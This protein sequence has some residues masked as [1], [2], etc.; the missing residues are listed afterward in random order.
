MPQFLQPGQS[1]QRR[2]TGARS[3]TTPARSSGRR[4]AGSPTRSP[5]PTATRTSTTARCTAL[6]LPRRLIIDPQKVARAGVG[7]VRLVVRAAATTSAARRRAATTSTS[8]CPSSRACPTGTPVTVT[9]KSSWDMEWDFDY[10]FVMATTDGTNYTSLPSANGY[11]TP[12]A[13]NPNGNGCQNTYGNGLTG[14]SG[15]AAGGLAQQQAD[16]ANA[17]VRSGL[18]VRRRRV[19]PL[20]AT[21][22]S[23]TSCC[24]SRT[25]PTRA[26]TAPGWFIDDL[27][28]KAGDQ[29]IYSSDFTNEDDAARVPGRLRHE[30]RASSPTAA[31]RAGRG[32]RRTTPARARPR[33]LRRAPRP[34]RLRLR[35]PRPGRPRRDRAGIRA[36]CIEYTD[37][38]RG[39]G[40]FSAVDPPRQ[41]Y[42]DSQPQPGLDCGDGLYETD[43][44]PDV[45]PPD[46]CED[47]A[48]TRARRRQPLQ[49]RRLDRQLRGRR[50]GG[51]PLALRL[52]LPD[53]RRA[54]D[55]RRHGQ[56]GGAA[57][58][59][60][61]EREAR[62]PARAA[63]AFDYWSASRTPRRR[64][65]VGYSRRR[66]EPA[67]R[68]RS[69]RPARSTT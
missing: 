58:R 19:R 12:G 46:R 10:G 42:L 69:T 68:S 61:R 47:A 33:L 51:R 64:R 8:P 55:V 31:P 32:S 26:S 27:V 4:R 38:V 67:R 66:R 11:T 24:A 2:R 18:A 3:R 48:F 60:D 39:Y 54:V 6:K 63:T 52:R 15:S 49:G 22:A 17:D 23:R 34:L 41:H 43:P 20:V 59:P 40:N 65:R 36:C 53:A 28:V 37:E 21:P 13:V 56:H 29:V 62:R 57:V 5:R 9:F 25:P 14:T 16:R 30:R 45:L 1:R 44:E 35:Q 7:A 50:V